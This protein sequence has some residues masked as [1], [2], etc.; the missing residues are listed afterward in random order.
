MNWQFDPRTVSELKSQRQA[1]EFEDF[2]LSPFGQQEFPFD[3]LGEK[4]LVT[5][6]ALQELVLSLTTKISQ[7]SNTINYTESFDPLRSDES[8]NGCVKYRILSTSKPTKTLNNQTLTEPCL[9]IEKIY[10]LKGIIPSSIF[11]DDYQTVPDSFKLIAEAS[12]TNST[13]AN[14]NPLSGTLIARVIV[15]NPNPD[16]PKILFEIQSHRAYFTTTDNKLMTAA[17]SYKIEL[18][19]APEDLVVDIQ[20]DATHVG[21][22]HQ[23]RSLRIDDHRVISHFLIDILG[24]AEVAVEKLKRQPWLSSNFIQSLTEDSNNQ[25]TN[26]DLVDNLLPLEGREQWEEFFVSV[27]LSMSC[28]IMPPVEHLAAINW[29]RQ[30]H[31]GKSE[32]Q[33]ILL[34]AVKKENSFDL[35]DYQVEDLFIVAV[36]DK[37]QAL[38][39]YKYILGDNAVFN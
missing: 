7:L 34:A 28:G 9:A 18:L 36:K 13:E 30:T 19:N 21:L 14:E 3:Q 5:L 15:Q 2:L 29:I 1:S 6:K 26:P 20:T 35:L 22:I 38:E 32:F 8:D 31:E 25:P 17:L 23:Q 12:Q 27:E 37:E 11:N 39:Y 10:K 16:N 33:R 4:R 24:W